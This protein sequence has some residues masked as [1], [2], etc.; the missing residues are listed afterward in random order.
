MRTKVLMVVLMALLGL[1]GPAAIARACSVD[2]SCYSYNPG[3]QMCTSNAQ[4]FQSMCY[5]SVPG[6]CA[7]S[8]GCPNGVCTEEQWPCDFACRVSE[9]GSCASQYCGDLDSCYSNHCYFN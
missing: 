4:T 8:C 3:Y 7:Q 5:S 6:R 2:W 9:D 1:V